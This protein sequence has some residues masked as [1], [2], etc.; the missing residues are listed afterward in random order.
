V[1]ST[2]KSSAS[3]LEWVRDLRSRLE[4]DGF[5]VRSSQLVEQGRAVLEDH[6]LMVAKFLGA[7]SQ[8]MIVVGG[9]G[10]A[11]TM[12]LSVLERTREIG[13]LRTLGARHR[14]IFAIVQAEGLVVT[15]ASG[16]LAIPLSIP[17]SW[18]LGRAFGRIM[19]PVPVNAIPDPT[20]VA[21]WLGM[22]LVVSFAACSWP[23]IRAT[24]LTPVAALSRE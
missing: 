5:V 14:T 4:S 3:Q 17:M 22:A 20:A 10:L 13:V 21:V 24:R 16:L 9:L 8:L 18:I 12:S 6:L 7:M 19:F 23:A 15:I 2:E 11:S 1:T